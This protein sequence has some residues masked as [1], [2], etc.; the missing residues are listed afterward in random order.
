M[1][2]TGTSV[3]SLRASTP[4]WWARRMVADLDHLLL[5]QA[6]LEK[7]AASAALAFL[8]RWPERP[9]LQVPLSRLARE[10][11]VHFERVVAVMT[12]RGVVFGP[13]QPGSYASLLKAEV[14]AP[15]EQ[16]LLDELLVSALIEAR[17]SERM[18]LLAGELQGEV[19]AVARLYA[20][21][22]VAEE[23]HKTVYCVLASELFGSSEVEERFGALARQEAEIMARVSQRPGLHSGWGEP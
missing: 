14:R 4:D 1:M 9:E 21:L 7:K 13:Q 6:H 17:S 11:L 16:R 15:K 19:Q 23:R 20:D 5:E 8:F 12:D 10:E 3:W 2:K 18:A 22:V